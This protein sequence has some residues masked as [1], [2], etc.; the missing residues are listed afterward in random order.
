MQA[1]NNQ[2][3][4]FDDSLYV[5]N[6]HVT[7]GLTGQNIVWAF[8][9]VEVANWHPITWLSHMA[10][11]QMFGMNP[12]GHH[13]T[14]VVMHT[15]STLLLFFLLLRLTG[16]RWQSAFVAAMFA[17][18]PLH[19][20]SVA[21]VAERKDVLSA[22]FWFLTLLFYSE[23]VAKRKASLYLL[24]LF[25]FML[26]LMSKPMLVTLPIV[27]LLLDYWP[28]DRFRYE[29]QQPGFR[30]IAG[31]IA[32][33]TKE[34]I[35][36]FLCS[37][38]S[39]LITIYAQRNSGAIA[40]FPLLPLRLR[41]E[42]ALVAYVTYIEKTFYPHDMAVY[43]PFPASIALWQIISSLGV[44]VFISFLV[45]RSRSAHPYR[46]AGWLW[47]IVTL[48]PVIGLM[49][50]GGQSMADRYTY[51]PT[52]GLFIMVAWG[53]P[54]LIK[55]VPFQRGILILL[56]GTALATSS[57][58]AWKQLGYWRDNVSLYQ[59]TLHVT[60]GNS[61]I[62]NNLGVALQEAGNSDAA[63]QEYQKALRIN[64]NYSDAHYNLGVSLRAKRNLNGA[65]QEFQEA[66]RLNPSNVDAHINLGVIRADKG[67][68][69][70]AIQH[71]QEALR[72]NP[73]NSVARYSLGVVVARKN[74]RDQNGSK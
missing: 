45:L 3:L 74:Y 15:L 47:F 38:L 10:D 29:G 39:C 72:V 18:H 64:P 34:K 55:G 57:L 27:M 30:Q 22:F 65:F 8:T 17:L 52:I 31:S 9:S 33:L 37:T 35:P 5:N 2:F 44:L 32:A 46:V 71:Y 4:N 66:L 69:D 61:L 59:H 58:L 25:S 53:A 51:I 24:A 19:V 21:W 68:L 60:T 48:V 50:V 13:L 1:G 14:S 26:G 11:V 56:A 28:L 73:D 42:N 23:Y 54:E 49:Q 67:E 63:I 43:Y 40:S 16:F 36:F 20:E 41:C 12:R 70:A 6:S 7:G 62:H